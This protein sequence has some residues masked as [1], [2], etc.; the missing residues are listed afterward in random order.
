MPPTRIIADDHAVSPVIG[1]IL[2]VAITVILSAVIGTFVL[3]LAPNGSTQP[4][5]NFGFS[6]DADGS[7]TGIAA[8]NLTGGGDAGVLTVTHEGGANV[9]ADRIELV[10]GA[11]RTGWADCGASGTVTAG[12]S[13]D[14]DVDSDQTL[15]VVWTAEGGAESA[16]LGEWVGSEA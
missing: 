9:D 1:V 5:T 8:C 2:M 7:P 13:V 16:V 15:R 3:G 11:N 6:F 12:G 14:V 10:T 4:Q